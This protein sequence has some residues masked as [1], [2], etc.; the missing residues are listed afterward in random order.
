MLI[1]G[2]NE[3]NPGKK[4]KFMLP[5]TNH[6]SGNE[7]GFPMMVVNGINDGPVLLVD[8]GIHGDEYESGEAIRQIWNNLDPMEL[9]GSFVGVPVVNVPSFEARAS[10]GNLPEAVT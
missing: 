10:L 1:F 3:I 6:P 8:G 2:N 5:I 7:I 4:T 9:N